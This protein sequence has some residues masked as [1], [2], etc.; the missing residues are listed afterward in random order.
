MFDP[1]R[2]FLAGCGNEERPVAAPPATIQLSSDYP[3]R[4][5]VSILRPYGAVIVFQVIADVSLEMPLANGL[6]QQFGDHPAADVSQ[7]LIAALETER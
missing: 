2:R 1:E 4:K 3:C 5:V 6:G 7:A